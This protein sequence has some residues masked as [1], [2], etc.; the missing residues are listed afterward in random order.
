MI[1]PFH[2]LTVATAV[3][4]SCRLTLLH[5]IYASRFSGLPSIRQTDCGTCS[6]ARSDA[7]ARTTATDVSRAK[8]RNGRRA[9]LGFIACSASIFVRRAHRAAG[10]WQ[11]EA[12]DSANEG[13]A[14]QSWSMLPARPHGAYRPFSG[15]CWTAAWSV[16]GQRHCAWCQDKRSIAVV[17]RARARVCAK[18]R[19]PP[20]HVNATQIRLFIPS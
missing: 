15:C 7:R 19:R 10:R 18:W 11:V 20:R 4:S 1:C 17:A 16:T 6:R 13:I 9:R 14:M 2:A 3:T 5:S 12:M 8:A